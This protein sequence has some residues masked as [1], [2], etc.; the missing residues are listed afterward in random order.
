MA[1]AS[2][3]FVVAGPAGAAP[4]DRSFG[5]NPLDQ[6]LAA[7]ADASASAKCSISANGLAALMLAPTY[8]ETGA[9]TS[10][11]PSP[12]TLSR[13]D[14]DVGLHSLSDPLRYPRVFWH[15]GIGVWQFD[16][17]GGWGKTAFER[18][19]VTQSAPMAAAEMSRRYCNAKNSGKDD[20]Q[21]RS[22]A[23]SPWHACRSGACDQIFFEIYVNSSTE[24]S[25]RRDTSVGNWGG[26]VSSTCAVPGVGTRSCHRVDPALAQGYK[27]WT[28]N[29]D[30]SPS[31][32][33]SL[34]FHV[35]RVGG[36]EWRV[37][38]AADTGYG[39]NI[40]ASKPLAANPRAK[41]NPNRSCELISPL[42]WYVNGSLVD[43]TDRTGCLDPVPP[44][45]L[46]RL[47]TSVSGTYQP[48]VGD[49]S[50]DG[51]DDVF[52]YAPGGAADYLWRAPMT[53]AAS[54]RTTVNGNYQP[55][56]GDFDGD[57]ADDIFWYAPG[58][59]MDYL[60]TGRST[61]P[62]FTDRGPFSVRG[63]YTPYVADF[64]GDQIDDIFWFDGNRSTNYLWLGQRGVGFSSR[65]VP[66]G[67]DAIDA[68]GDFDGDGRAD[69][70][71]HRPG[72]AVDSIF[73]STGTGFTRHDRSVGGSYRL[74]VGDFDGNGA[75]DI[76][77]QG[78]NSNDAYLWFHSKGVGSRSVQPS[79]VRQIIGSNRVPT[80]VDGPVSSELLWIGPGAASDEYWTF[81][82]QSPSHN[83]DLTVEDGYRF[84]LAG[85]FTAN[86]GGVL[87]Y[88]P[89]GGTDAFWL[90]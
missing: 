25:V 72:A 38:N 70:V 20:A 45:T 37:W 77:W 88:N 42:R 8:P 62:W 53:Q 13:W 64:D 2:S 11:S 67:L 76:L 16:S 81:S 85:R 75:D 43:S 57:G 63:T 52:W 30:G 36:D 12:M 84:V 68:V 26:V 24:P 10:A 46:N 31:A 48:L 32:P 87:F 86:G 78:T 23:W 3:L 59:A 29:P 18:M 5:D 7:A 27:G 33:L 71:R 21:A 19:D 34:P 47:A 66:L 54:T 50:G 9:G 15:P 17:V 6:V 39:V 80:V 79:G 56:V 28:A 65:A 55:L 40:A 41:P 89:G 58:A 14:R 82:G 35:T 1:V 90:R 73:Y 44:T 49:F 69:L 22:A 61:S 4:G 83:D 51:L 60:H 74:T